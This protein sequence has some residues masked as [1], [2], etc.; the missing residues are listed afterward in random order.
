[1]SEASSES[2]ANRIGVF[3]QETVIFDGSI[4]ENIAY[5]KSESTLK[6]IEAAAKKVHIHDYVQDLE[7][8]YD[9]MTGERGNK[10][11]DH[12]DCPQK[13]SRFNCGSC[14]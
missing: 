6:E 8:Q 4:A 12:H 9:T 10:I 1:L 7:N 3:T 14:Y 2:F 11:H 13:I 5:Y